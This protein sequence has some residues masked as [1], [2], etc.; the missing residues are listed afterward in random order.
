MARKF[1]ALI[2]ITILALCDL[3]MGLSKA[4]T[5]I[6]PESYSEI[7]ETNN[8]FSLFDPSTWQVGIIPIV[9]FLWG[10]GQILRMLV[11]QLKISSVVFMA[12]LCVSGGV[13]ITYAWL[14]GYTRHADF[15]LWKYLV[16][17]SIGAGSSALF[18]F[19]VLRNSDYKDEW[20]NALK[21]KSTRTRFKDV[22]QCSLILL[23]FI[24]AFWLLEIYV[25]FSGPC[26]TRKCRQ[27]ELLLGAKE[28]SLWLL[29]FFSLISA[30]VLLAVIVNLWALW[31]FRNASPKKDESAT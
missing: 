19:I 27:G 28:S 5:V 10:A 25:D 3:P 21:N 15:V 11:G 12:S 14:L 17:V 13:V 22:G 24:A 2:S 6:G 18:A 29:W 8:W 9:C 1:A 4:Q 26:T 23:G 30:I 31:R 20:V 7:S 16:L